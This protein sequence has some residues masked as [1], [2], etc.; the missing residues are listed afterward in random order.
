MM[1]N[2]P[3]RANDHGSLEPDLAGKLDTT[4]FHVSEL[5]GPRRGGTSTAARTQIGRPDDSRS[6]EPARVEPG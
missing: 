2:A 5:L 6:K 3:T 4:C 1:F